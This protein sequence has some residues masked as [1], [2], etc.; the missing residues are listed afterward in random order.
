[1]LQRGRFLERL[2]APMRVRVPSHHSAGQAAGDVSH[3]WMVWEDGQKK[4]ALL[5][6][7]TCPA[8]GG[9]T[10]QPGSQRHMRKQQG[11]FEELLLL[12]GAWMQEF[13]V[14]KNDN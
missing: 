1:M 13:I 2:E 14:R 3:S 11:W 9:V 6:S 8:R 12:L 7:A 5:P 4:A 10:K